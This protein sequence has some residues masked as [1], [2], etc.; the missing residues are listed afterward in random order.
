MSTPLVGI[1]VE[2]SRTGYAWRSDPGPLPG[3]PKPYR[4]DKDR[5][6]ALNVLG[7]KTIPLAPMWSERPRDGLWGYLRRLVRG[8]CT[9]TGKIPP[10]EWLRG[11][12]HVDDHGVEW[13][14]T[15]N[16]VMELME[17]K[18]EYNGQSLP[19]YYKVRVMIPVMVVAPGVKTTSSGDA[20]L[21]WIWAFG[22]SGDRNDDGAGPIPPMPEGASG[23]VA[24]DAIKA[25]WPLIEAQQAAILKALHLDTAHGGHTFIA[26]APVTMGVWSAFDDYVACFGCG[27][28]IWMPTEVRSKADWADTLVAKMGWKRDKSGAVF[29]WTCHAKWPKVNVEV[30]PCPTTP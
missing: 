7:I 22:N 4:V 21:V 1:V 9:L 17:A 23:N 25:W 27:Y 11:R 8:R 2:G 19:A 13:L 28:R 10:R 16:T 5:P 15:L 14:Q 3:K 26:M 24:T 29:C 12:C 18:P 6:P 20:R 30:P